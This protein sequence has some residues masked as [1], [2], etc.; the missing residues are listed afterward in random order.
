L[1]QT[2][3]FLLFSMPTVLF[4]LDLDLSFSLSLPFL[5]CGAWLTGCV[6]EARQRKLW[7]WR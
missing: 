6:T 1:F 2:L 3:S 5:L 7:P 4:L